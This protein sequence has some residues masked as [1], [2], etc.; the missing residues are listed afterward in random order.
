MGSGSCL[1]G[2]YTRYFFRYDMY[3]SNLY[4]KY[5]I[6]FC[7]PKKAQAKLLTNL[8]IYIRI[9]LVKL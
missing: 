3:I 8:C 2:E 4:A 1:V 6:I 5:A 7:H 9:Y